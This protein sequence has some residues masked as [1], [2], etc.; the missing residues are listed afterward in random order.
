MSN[1]SDSTE[2]QFLKKSSLKSDRLELCPSVHEIVGIT[3]AFNIFSEK[4]DKGK[5]IHCV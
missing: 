1:F 4:K 2:I 5:T 3:F